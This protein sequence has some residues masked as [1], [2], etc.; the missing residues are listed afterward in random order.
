MFLASGLLLIAIAVEVVATAMLPKAEGFTNPAWTAAV[1]SGYAVSIW[2]LT[3][4]VRQLPVSVTYA[5]WSGLGTAAIAVIGVLYLH[6]S[7]DAFKI[8]GISLVIAGVVLLNLHTA[9]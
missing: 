5:V 8:A 9:S 3:L 1:L 7:V 6:E 2:L 4:I